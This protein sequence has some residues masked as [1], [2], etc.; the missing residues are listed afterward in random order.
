MISNIVIPMAGGIIC[1]TTLQQSY[2]ITA[3]FFC[4][5]SKTEDDVLTIYAV[6]AND[7]PSDASMLVNQVTITASDTFE[8]DTEKLVL[9]KGY[10][11]YAKAEK[12]HVSAVLSIMDVS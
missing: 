10:Y 8:L 5:T 7:T 6:S 9:E 11:I 3:A 4:N 12:G 2:A 1:Q